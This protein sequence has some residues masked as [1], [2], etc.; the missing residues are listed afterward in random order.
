MNRTQIRGA[1]RTP[2]EETWETGDAVLSGALYHE[3]IWIGSFTNT[4][5]A[6]L[7]KEAPRLARALL[8]VVEHDR[9]F[10]E[11]P[12]DASRSPIELVTEALAAAGVP[13]P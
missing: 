7:A 8:A 6:R 3:G 13:I 1:H 12:E 5:R 4:E 11:S 10:R 9:R 2:H